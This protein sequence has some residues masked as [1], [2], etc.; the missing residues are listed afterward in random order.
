[1]NAVFQ[2][3]HVSV[4]LDGRTALD[5]EH[6]ELRGGELIGLIGS[7]GSG[8][9]TL[10]R[11]LA[12]LISVDEG[13]VHGDRSRVAYV[14][15]RQDQHRWMPLTVTEVL[16]M[17]RYGQTGLLGRLGGTDRRA[18]TAA[19]ERLQISDLID[20]PFGDLSGG[21]KQRVL[22]ATALTTDAPTLLLDEPIT[23]LDLPSQQIITAIAS[24]ERDV[25][26]LV[27]ISTHHLDEAR[28]CDRVILLA[29][30]VVA[31]GTPDE[32]LQPA[33]LAEAFG[34]RVVHLDDG[35]P[36]AAGTIFLDDCV[37]PGSVHSTSVA[38]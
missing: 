35:S 1:M 21:Q 3:D 10:L 7:N 17:G 34:Q 5:V 6:L 29:N 32:V 19:A 36:D 28:I 30:R 8:K 14:G 12:N 33:L 13:T 9:T 38:P 16:R 22:L 4:R 23:G 20:R 26:R 11:V 25:G 24:E 18:I 2:L 37:H 27:V 31:D 15:Q